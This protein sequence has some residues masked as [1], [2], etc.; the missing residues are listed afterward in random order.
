MS[1][2]IATAPLESI[3]W[4]TLDPFLFCAH[5]KDAYPQG[6]DHLAPVASL[7]GRQIGNDF[8]GKDGWSMYHGDSIP[9]FPQHP[10]RG[11]ETITIARSGFID[12]SDSLGAA[13]RFGKGDVQWMTAGKGIVH[14]E[15]FPLLDQENGNPAE[16]FQIWLN[17]P[18]KN[19][20]AQPYFSMY[21]NETIPRVDI[22]DPAGKRTEILVYAGEIPGARG[23][24]PPPDSWAAS[25]ESD[26]KI[27]TIRMEAGASWT[28]PP[29][30]PGSNRVIYF[31]KGNRATIAGTDTTVG[32]AVQLVPES[33]ASIQAGSEP[34]EILLL[35]GRP[36]G[37]P[38]ARY[39][40]FVMNTQQEIQQAFDDYRLTS[41]GG[42][43]WKEDAP[44][45]DKAQGRFARHADGHVETP[46][47]A[48]LI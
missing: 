16:L 28:L 12:H 10:H 19:K 9:G 20:M 40:P 38:V 21:W 45:H 14:S 43:P 29:A 47:G 33:D 24:V 11:F 39:G 23:V 36:I 27:L 48:A 26:I 22:V 5:H 42:W 15:M 7:E 6:N 4:P 41:F 34:C 35:Q 30:R 25:P 18:M 46:S 32:T 2:I 13:A 31:F 1:S 3:P 44:V 37:E 17:L 8:S